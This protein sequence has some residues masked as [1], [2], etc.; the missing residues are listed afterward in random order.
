MGMGG[1]ALFLMGII[2]LISGAVGRRKN[3]RCSAQTEGVVTEVRER[4]NSDTTL[5]SMYVYAYSV[6]GVE[7]RTKST[8]YVKG[9]NGIGDTCTIWYNPKKPK[10]AQPF[11]SE[12]G[13]AFRIILIIGIVLTLAGVVMMIVG[14]SQ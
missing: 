6:D 14:L 12:T 7:Y 9:V 4:E 2:L 13:K 8:A 11:H 5:P 3:K 10:D 1:F